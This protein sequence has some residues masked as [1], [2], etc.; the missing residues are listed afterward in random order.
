MSGP[1]WAG[2][3]RPLMTPLCSPGSLAGPAVHLISGP[4]PAS[5]GP[6]PDVRDPGPDITGDNTEITIVM[7]S[8]EQDDCPDDMQDA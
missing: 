7:M 2:V 1:H 4:R 8:N 5:A 3:Y 6:T